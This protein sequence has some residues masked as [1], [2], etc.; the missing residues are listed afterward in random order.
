MYQRLCGLGLGPREEAVCCGSC[1]LV[2]NSRGGGPF[3]AS[4]SN[5]RRSETGGR[6]L[7]HIYGDR[8]NDE[9]PMAGEAA[10]SRAGKRLPL[11]DGDLA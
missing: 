4:T 1:S 9:V 6:H 3:Y 8:G 5:T 2:S 11:N 10:P 7:T